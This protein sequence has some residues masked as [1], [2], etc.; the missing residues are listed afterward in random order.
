VRWLIRSI[1]NDIVF[2]LRRL[3]YDI[4]RGLVATCFALIGLVV[5]DNLLGVTKLP[6]S[7]QAAFAVGAILALVAILSINRSWGGKYRKVI[8]KGIFWV[9][10]AMGL[11]VLTGSGERQLGV[12][13]GYLLS[14]YNVWV[15]ILLWVGIVISSPF[16]IAANWAKDGEQL[17]ES[18]LK[19]R[20]RVPTIF[21]P[22]FEVDD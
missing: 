12:F 11:I 17:V 6:Y 10:G 19:R 15:A 9:F 16:F 1:P 13:S 3:P 21:N 20:E 5:S 7:N 4:L 2:V 8:M 14:V 18:E 22:Q